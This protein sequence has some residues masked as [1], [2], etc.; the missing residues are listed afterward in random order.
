VYIKVAQSRIPALVCTVACNTQNTVATTSVYQKI[1][2][3]VFLF[4]LCG[5]AVLV[6]ILWLSVAVHFISELTTFVLVNT[7][8]EYK[9]VYLSPTLRINVFS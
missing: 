4:D 6:R 1:L 8:F 3:F 5:L 9:Y 2:C 7:V